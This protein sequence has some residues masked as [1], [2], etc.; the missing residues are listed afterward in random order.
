MDF[1]RAG[2][3][4]IGFVAIVFGAVAFASVFAYGTGHPVEQ[5]AVEGGFDG[6]IAS[7]ATGLVGAV[8]LFLKRPQDKWDEWKNRN[9]P[10]RN[11]VPSDVEKALEKHLV[12]C[13]E[14]GKQARQDRKEMR[15]DIAKT[16]EELAALNAKIDVFLGLHKGTGD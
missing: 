8:T 15:M 16:R 12:D 3:R 9:N 2:A 4:L 6:L 11:H 1:F 13:L 10:D 14:N 5:A 7:L